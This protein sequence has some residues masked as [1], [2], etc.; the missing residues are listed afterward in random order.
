VNTSHGVSNY[1]EETIS[2]RHA[3]EGVQLV[4]PVPSLT[5]PAVDHVEEEAAKNTKL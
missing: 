4:Q 2:P 3:A 1:P 5:T